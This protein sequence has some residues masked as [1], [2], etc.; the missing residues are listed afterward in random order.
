MH[1]S[2]CYV[3]TNPGTGTKHESD[4]SP[5]LHVQQAED[6]L[7]SSSMN[8]REDPPPLPDRRWKAMKPKPIST[9]REQGIKMVNSGTNTKY[10]SGSSPIL[11]VPNQQRQNELSGSGVDPASPP[12]H[13]RHRGGGASPH[14]CQ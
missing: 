8:P 13:G 9:L 5:M 6:G 2:V 3:T 10:E 4:S 12:V 14:K 11:H 1:K 7:S